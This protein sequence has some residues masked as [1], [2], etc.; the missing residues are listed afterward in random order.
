[1]PSKRYRIAPSL[2]A[3]QKLL[4]GLNLDIADA[5]GQLNAGP[6]LS[7]IVLH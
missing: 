7:W 3:P 6:S 1:M 5:I 2:M 4:L